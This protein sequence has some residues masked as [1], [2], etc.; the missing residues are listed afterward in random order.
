MCFFND[1]G[2]DVRAWLSAQP[3]DPWRELAEYRQGRTAGAYG[4]CCPFVGYMRDCNQE[5]Q[6]REMFLEHYPAMTEQYLQKLVGDAMECHD[7][8]DALVIH[9]VGRVLPGEAIVLAAVWSAH[10]R[11]AF[12]VCRELVERLKFHAPFWKKERTESG[13]LWVEDNTPRAE[14][15]DIDGA[16]PPKGA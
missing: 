14:R 1:Q 13:D 5:R 16:A 15:K 10:R 8:L 9:R 6:V 4:A 12:D 7:I 11:E 2:L 3:F